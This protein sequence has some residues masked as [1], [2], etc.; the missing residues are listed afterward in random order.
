MNGS[1]INLEHIWPQSKGAGDGTDGQSDMHH[2]A[3]SRV[4]VNSMRANN[5]FD[6]IPDNQTVKWYYL[7]ESLMSTPAMMI[8]SYSEADNIRFEPREDRKGDI[9]K[10]I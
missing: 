9:P 4:D 7:E 1:G 8:D 2:L 5:P 10:F 3:P 6:E